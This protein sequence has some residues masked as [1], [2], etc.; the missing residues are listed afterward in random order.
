MLEIYNDKM[1]RMEAPDLSKGWLEPSTRTER[2]EAVEGVEEVW[3]YETVRE[4]PNGGK[5]VQKVVTV[6]GVKA[7]P[8]WDEEI[9]IHI[10][11]PYTQEELD[12]MKEREEAPTSEERIQQLEE[13]L[14]LLLSGVTE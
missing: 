3:H 2:H 4:Y 7:S 1:E 13:A 8:A 11:H 10:Y 5:D 6:P 12:A 14:E 9:E